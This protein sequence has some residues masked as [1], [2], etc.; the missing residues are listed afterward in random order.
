MRRIYT[1]FQTLSVY[2]AAII[3]WC[4]I[5][6]VII[7]VINPQ[8][9]LVAASIL[10]F[11]TV[12]SLLRFF[13]LA[14]WISALIGSAVYVIINY[15]L[16][17]LTRSMLLTTGSVVALYFVAAFLA[18]LYSHQMDLLKGQ[19]DKSQRML[20]DLV[21]YDPST[22]VYRWK[23]ARQRL[24][25]EVLRSRRYKKPLTLL[26]IKPHLPEST[27]LSEKERENLAAQI[28]E[29]LLNGIRRDV[30]IPFTGP[31]MGIIL[32]ETGS[33]GAQILSSRLVEDVFR[34]LRVEL[35]V[36]I[37]SIPNDAVTDEALLTDAE[38]AMKFAITSGQSVIPFSRIREATHESAETISQQSAPEVVEPVR[39][40]KPEAGPL[41]QDTEIGSDEWLVEFENFTELTQ[42]PNLQKVVEG[43]PEFSDVQ[44]IGLNGT[45]LTIKMKSKEAQIAAKIGDLFGLPVDAVQQ[46]GRV[47]RA[48]LKKEAIRA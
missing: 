14:P 48:I 36:G 11:I 31:N 37:A 23:Y 9:S 35:A 24:T 12:F 3:V 42:F 13:P 27:A 15:S 30:D 4:V 2:S 29:T 26:L 38:M 17:T 41:L 16:F 22:G 7:A 47:V 46:N 8:T 1:N 20:N 45:T 40:A 19:I 18:E 33:E 10:A 32:P 44:L 25:M 34:K 6:T 5:S 39:I 43:C 28:I 21:Q